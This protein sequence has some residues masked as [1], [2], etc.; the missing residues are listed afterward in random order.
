MSSYYDARSAIV[1][2][3]EGV[4]ITSPQTVQIKKVWPYIPDSGELQG[5][6][7]AVAIAGFTS[8]HQRGPSGTRY[9]TFGITIRLYVR[10]VSNKQ[11]AMYDMLDAF[12]LAI[13]AAFDPAVTVNLGAGFH[14]VEGPNWVLQEP[15]KEAGTVSDDAVIV[16]KISDVVTFGP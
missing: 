5:N 8:V 2:V 13:S 11:A 6:F 4:S 16:L 15:V 10:P 9:Q 14:V 1:S 12:K 3:L 7:P